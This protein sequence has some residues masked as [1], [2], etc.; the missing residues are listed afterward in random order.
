MYTELLAELVMFATQSSIQKRALL[1]THRSMDDCR[2]DQSY[3][4]PLN[5]AGLLDMVHFYCADHNSKCKW[6]RF[7]FSIF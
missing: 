7:L 1:G 3:S 6:L 5:S 2:Y 4:A